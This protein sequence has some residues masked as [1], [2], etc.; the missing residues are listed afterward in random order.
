LVANLTRKVGGAKIWRTKTGNADVAQGGE[1]RTGRVHTK[2]LETRKANKGRE[3]E[4]ETGKKYQ[5]FKAG[6]GGKQRRIS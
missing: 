2:N 6:T 4:C 3:P 1:L 5:G